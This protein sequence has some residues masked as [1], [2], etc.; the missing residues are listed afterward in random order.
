M[1]IRVR[2]SVSRGGLLLRGLTLRGARTLKFTLGLFPTFEHRIERGIEG[3]LLAR[4][5]LTTRVQK[6]PPHIDR[7]SR[8]KRPLENVG[9][10]EPIAP[11]GSSQFEP[12]GCDAQCQS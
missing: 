3:L 5:L 6:L 10:A 2:A 8:Q 11:Q 7:E 1:L 9:P 12:E 4:A